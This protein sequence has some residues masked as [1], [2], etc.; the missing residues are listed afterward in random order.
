MA[1]RRRRS[2]ARR[3]VALAR[4]LRDAKSSSDRVSI[5]LRIM[6]TRWP[7]HPDTLSRRD[8]E[9]DRMREVYRRRAAS[10]ALTDVQLS[11]SLHRDACTRSRKAPAG[12]C[13]LT[14][15]CSGIR[16]FRSPNA[17]RRPCARPASPLLPVVARLARHAAIAPGWCSGSIAAARAAASCTGCPR[18][19]RSTSCI[20]SGGAR[21][22]SARIVPRWVKFDS[23]GA[24][25]R[26]GFRRQARPSAIRAAGCTLDEQ[27]RRHRTACGAFGS[28]PDY[29]ERT[30]VRSS[31]HG[32]VD[33]YLE[34]LRRAQSPRAAAATLGRDSADRDVPAAVDVDRLA[35]DVRRLGQQ[36]V[37]GL[38]DVVGRRPRAS[39]ACAR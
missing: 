22:S 33:P 8:L 28:S 30:R 29:L 6:T 5:E 31:T 10:H 23:E 32:I 9:D 21:W 36:E 34:R 24:H 38:R 26:A 14:G 25:H 35:G 27:A 18:R 11:E 1:S 39:A 7:H 12:G 20:C 16:C 17:R 3:N 4:Q 13:S 2:V 15:R 19:W 37:D